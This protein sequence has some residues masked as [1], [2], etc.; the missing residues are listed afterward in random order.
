MDQLELFKGKKLEILKEL[1]RVCVAANI[2][3]FLAYGTLLGA[4][5]HGGFIPWDDDIDVFMTYSE[6]D[7]LLYHQDL[8]KSNYFIQSVHTEPNYKKMKVSFRDSNTS[9]F[10]SEKDCLDMNHGIYIDIYILY[11]YPDN[12]LRA[13]KL[14]I[15]TYILRILYAKNVPAN[16]GNIAKIISRIP[17]YIYRGSKARKKIEKIENELS[18]N[19]GSKYLSSYYGEDITPFSTFKFPKEY[20]ENPKYLQFEDMVAPCPSNPEDICKITYGNTYMQLPPIEERIP[21]HN[22]RFV[23]FSEP[24]THYEGI[25]YNKG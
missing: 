19:G 10:A 20:F 12:F 11:P 24:Y 17:L 2:K 8:L 5:R 6:F 21:R 18:G 22:L 1:D 13:H 14:I 15:D 16:H 7:K 9:F 23:S 25:Y 3:Y 4:V